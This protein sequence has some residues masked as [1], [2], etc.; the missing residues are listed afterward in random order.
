MNDP[1]PLGKTI[2]EVGGLLTGIDPDTRARRYLALLA[3][4]DGSFAELGEERV[5]SLDSWPGG[6]SNVPVQALGRDGRITGRQ[7]TNAFVRLVNP[8][9]DRQPPPQLF[10]VL[11]GEDLLGL[12]PLSGNGNSLHIEPVLTSP[13]LRRQDL[14]ESLRGQTLTLDDLVLS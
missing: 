12:V 3:F 8:D 13:L 9:A 1:F 7:I 6:A 10:L 11:D 4:S 5:A 14:L 2:T